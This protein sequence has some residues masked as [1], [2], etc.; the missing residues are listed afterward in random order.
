MSP[1]WKFDPYKDLEPETTAN[2]A[3]VA[4]EDPNKLAQRIA[5]AGLATLAAPSAEKANSCFRS[6]A[7]LKGVTEENC[8]PRSVTPSLTDIPT[9]WAAGLQGM[10]E[11]P[12]PTTIEPRRWLQLQEDANRFIDQWGG[13]AAALGWSTVDIFGCHPRHPADRFDA[14]GL[15]WMIADA[16]V[17]AMGAEVVNLRKAD[18]TIQRVWKCPVIHGRVLVWDL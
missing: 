11:R 3:K 8:P 12:C 4:K 18:G 10:A 6:I 15:V 7:P 17:V 13:Q 14:M 1:Y 5:L 16:K 9:D 2:V